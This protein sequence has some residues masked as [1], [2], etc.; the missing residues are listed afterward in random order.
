MHMLDT[1]WLL[2]YQLI[3]KITVADL[4]DT[5]HRIDKLEMLRKTID[6]E[7]KKSIKEAKR[8]LRREKRYRDEFC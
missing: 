8:R 7:F 2:G 3:E 1:I 4:S 6:G 5:Q